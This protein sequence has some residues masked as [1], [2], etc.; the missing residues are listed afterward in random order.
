[1]AT[2]AKK[3]A[4]YGDLQDIFSKELPINAARVKFIV[5]LVASLIKV[6]SVNFERLAQGF[7]NRVGLGSNLRRIQRFFAAFQLDGDLVARFLFKLLPVSGPHRLS[8]DRTNWKFGQVKLNI[9][10]LGV[11]HKGLCL[12]ILW[13]FLGDKRGNS[14]QNERI[15]LIER[16]VRLFGAHSIE[17]L[18]ADREFVGETWW[19]YLIDRKIRI[20]IRLRANM[21]L[22]LPGKGD[23]K[24]FWLFNPLPINTFYQHPKIVRIKGCWLYVCGL[25]FINQRGQVEFLIVASYDKAPEILG[26]YKERWQIE[27]MFKAFK[28]AGFNLESTHLTDFERLDR[29]LMLVAVAFSWAYKTGIFRHHHLKPIKI[30]KHGRLEKSLFAYGLELLAQILINGFEHEF[31][32]IVQPFL[33]CT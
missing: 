8:L 4:K 29:L 1:M 13:V 23:V 22:H 28:T 19:Q 16:Y 32:Q 14:S 10:V 9:L 7:D 11:V 15:A 3:L 17:S 30:K 20:F 26:Y 33:S 25:K 2:R 6:Q 18:T 21:H 24:A 5:L 12:P 27:T 31:P